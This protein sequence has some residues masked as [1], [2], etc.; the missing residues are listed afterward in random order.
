[1]FRKKSTVSYFFFVKWSKLAYMYIINLIALV[2]LQAMAPPLCSSSPRCKNL[3]ILLLLVIFY[4]QI[5]I[6]KK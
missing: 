1:M 6:I 4:L 3:S 2:L 5:K